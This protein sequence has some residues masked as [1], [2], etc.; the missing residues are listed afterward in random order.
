MAKVKTKS[1]SN[2]PLSTTHYPLPTKKAGFTLTEVLMAMAVLLI[3]VLGVIQLFPTGLNASRES[4]DETV[5]TNLVQAKLENFKAANYDD[6]VNEDRAKVSTNPND[7]SYKFDRQTQV[8]YVDTNL[9][10]STQDLGLKKII[11]TVFW[12]ENGQEKSV[13]AT[14]LKNK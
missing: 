5:A 8:Q 2:H 10:Q 7:P 9:A 3:G 12:Q 4:K 6:I 14:L 1:Q 11:V 13:S